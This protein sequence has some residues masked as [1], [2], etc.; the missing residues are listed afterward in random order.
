MRGE[1]YFLVKTGLDARFGFYLK[2]R[3]TRNFDSML[4]RFLRLLRSFS[5][6]KLN[7]TIILGPKMYM[8][9][10][11]LISRKK[12]GEKG[13]IYPLITLLSVVVGFRRW[14]NWIQC[15]SGFNFLFLKNVLDVLKSSYKHY[16][17]RYHLVKVVKKSRDNEHLSLVNVLSHQIILPMVPPTPMI[18]FRI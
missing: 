14:K 7:S 9:W 12:S 4:K 18:V 1:L 11:G 3:W 16:K 13:S 5:S 8:G 2:T 10:V 17:L 6:L 15:N